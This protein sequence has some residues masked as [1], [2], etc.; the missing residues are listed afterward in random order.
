MCSIINFSS[1]TFVLQKY[2]LI[3]NTSTSMSFYYYI[4]NIVFEVITIYFFH[5]IPEIE[6]FGGFISSVVGTGL[7]IAAVGRKRMC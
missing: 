6:I 2:V 4:F 1:I 7:V 3:N 5:C